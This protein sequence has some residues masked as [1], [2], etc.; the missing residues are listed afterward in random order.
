MV[1]IHLAPGAVCN[2]ATTADL[3][4]IKQV[5]EDLCKQLQTQRRSMLNGVGPYGVGSYP[6]CT[7]LQEWNRR[8]PRFAIPTSF[9]ASILQK[10]ERNAHE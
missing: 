8:N 4:Y 6:K 3:E 7:D 5:H 9:F 10:A 1:K 2:W